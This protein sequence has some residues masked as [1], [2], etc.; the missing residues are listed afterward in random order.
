LPT[1][2]AIHEVR[3]SIHIAA[4]AGVVWKNI[5][6]RSN[7]QPDELRGGF[8]YNIGVPYPAEARTLRDSVG[9]SRHLIWQRG[10]S[11]EENITAWEKEK[12]IAWSYVFRKGSFPAGLMDEHVAIGGKYFN[13]EDTSYT[14]KPETDGTRLDV[15]VGY[16]VSTNFN[17]YEEPLAK[18]MISN[19]AGTYTPKQKS[20]EMICSPKISDWRPQEAFTVQVA[21]PRQRLFRCA[22]QQLATAAFV[23]ASVLPRAHL[24]HAIANRDGFLDLGLAAMVAARQCNIAGRCFRLQQRVPMASLQKQRP[25]GMGK[26]GEG[27]Q[28]RIFL[29][30]ADQHHHVPAARRIANLKEKTRFRAFVREILHIHHVRLGPL[31]HL[32]DEFLAQRRGAAVFARILGVPIPSAQDAMAG[33]G[34]AIGLVEKLSEIQ[35]FAG[36]VRHQPFQRQ[37]P[38]FAVGEARAGA[39]HGALQFRG[40]AGRLHRAQPFQAPALGH[41]VHQHFPLLA[42]G[43]GW[44]GGGNAGWAGQQQRGDAAAA[45]NHQ[46]SEHFISSQGS[47]DKGGA[48]R[49]PRRIV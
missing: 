5:N 12:K 29:R 42:H 22:V 26:R 24:E 23:A 8:A 38:L 20:N 35:L 13:L 14:L 21:R 45:Q 25:L 30:D 15:K 48:A 31:L 34:C 49:G 9:G 27:V 10:V 37:A 36:T 28:M 11:F 7:I 3:Q 47:S 19:T 40:R 16:W 32:G 17:W 18:L 33:L 4:P 44:R 46:A 6:F 1:P 43:L 39:A 2:D 41:A